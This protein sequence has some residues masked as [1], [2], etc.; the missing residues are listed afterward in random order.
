M[1]TQHLLHLNHNKNNYSTENHST[2]TDSNSNNRSTL[3]NLTY[4]NDVILHP[5]SSTYETHAGLQ[6]QSHNTIKRHL[7][8][9]DLVSIG[10]GSTIGSGIFVLS[11]VIAHDMSGPSSAISWALSGTAALLC[12]S[13][14][15]ELAGKIP[16]EGSSYAYVYRTM[17]E[18]PAV[19]AALCLS[20]EYMVAS[21]AIAR[22]W[23]DKLQN[24]VELNADNSDSSV[25][26][27]HSSSFWYTLLW[28]HSPGGDSGSSITQFNT[29]AFLIS[30]GSIALLLRGVKESKRV[31]NVLTMVKVGV[32]LFMVIGG[33]MLFQPE[34]ITPF[35]PPEFGIRGVMRGAT[36]SFFGYLGFDEVCCLGGEA[37]NPEKNMPRAVMIVLVVR[38]YSYRYLYFSNSFEWN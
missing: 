12:G 34:N 16:A 9:F 4:E 21:A 24:W 14:Y 15:A 18:L 35:V 36:T 32:V 3:S 29:C 17:G 30:S 33:L 22:S 7:S 8:L 1:S 19:I 10:I 6:T 13:C 20:Y 2:N 11:G 27:E 23:G 28:N 5:S 26:T 37:I 31:T 25:V 38:L